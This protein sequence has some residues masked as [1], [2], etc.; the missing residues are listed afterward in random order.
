MYDIVQRQ[1]VKVSRFACDN[2]FAFRAT[3]TINIFFKT[4]ACITVLQTY[5]GVF[6]QYT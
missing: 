3:P 6:Q 2:D 1:F 5:A 4:A